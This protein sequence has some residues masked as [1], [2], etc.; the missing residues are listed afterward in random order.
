VSSL[1]GSC[2][3]V[4]FTLSGTSVFADA[5]TKYRKGNCQHL[6]AHQRVIVAGERQPDGRV[7]AQQIDFEE[8][9]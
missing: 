8:K 7:R 2:P 9:D 6:E 1:G 4:T 5:S 3:D